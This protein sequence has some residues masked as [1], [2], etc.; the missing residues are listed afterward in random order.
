MDEYIQNMIDKAKKAQKELESYSQEQIDE[1]VKRIAKVVFDN[2]ELC[3]KIA[4]EE[5]GMG[6]VEHKVIIKNATA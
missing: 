5:L 1:L 6:N 2:A 3:A 4:V